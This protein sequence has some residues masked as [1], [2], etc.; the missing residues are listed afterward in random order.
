MLWT[1]GSVQIH[2]KIK[3]KE[4]GRL[5]AIHIMSPSAMTKG[6]T[7]YVTPPIYTLLKK[8]CSRLG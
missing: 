6:D 7:H 5:L 3:L 2:A 8:L 1:E 4:A